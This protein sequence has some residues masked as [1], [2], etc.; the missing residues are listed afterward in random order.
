MHWQVSNRG[1]TRIQLHSE[2]CVVAVHLDTIFPYDSLIFLLTLWKSWSMRHYHGFNAQAPDP[3]IALLFRDGAMYYAF[4]LLASL[5]HIITFYT[6]GTYTTQP[7]FTFTANFSAIMASRMLL[8]L[9][10][11][12]DEGILSSQRLIDIDSVPAMPWSEGHD[13]AIELETVSSLRR[14]NGRVTRSII[15][16]SIMDLDDE[17]VEIERDD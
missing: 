17:I 9:H 3:L 6:S 1:S 7:L 14:R 2:G 8:N 11:S 10:K 13:L 4:K 12:V 5:A 15:L 16:D